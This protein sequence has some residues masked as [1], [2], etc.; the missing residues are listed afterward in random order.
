MKAFMF[1]TKKQHKSEGLLLFNIKSYDMVS[2]Y[3]G[4]EPSVLNSLNIYKN[5]KYES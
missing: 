1:Y 2:T 4:L 5:W 3:V